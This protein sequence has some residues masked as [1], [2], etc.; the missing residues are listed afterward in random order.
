VRRHLNKAIGVGL[1][2]IVSL[3]PLSCSRAQPN[4]SEECCAD[5]SVDR[6]LEMPPIPDEL[7]AGRI[8]VEV[9]F[10]AKGVVATL[11]DRNHKIVYFYS[12]D[13]GTSWRR[14]EFYQD[15]RAWQSHI[16]RDGEI[17]PWNPNPADASVRYR[18][19]HFPERK[20]YDERST[21][22]GKSWTR[23]KGIILGC[24]AKMGKGGT[25]F[26]HPRDPLT[27]Y[28]NSFLPGWDGEVMFVSVD[29]G[30]TFRSM[31]ES[32]GA[33]LLAISHSNPKVMYGAGPSGSLLKSTDGGKLWDLVGQ[34]DP[35]RRTRVRMSDVGTGSSGKAFDEWPTDIDD[36][37]IDPVDANRVYVAT[38]KG[39]LRTE[40]GG[41]TWCILDAGMTKARAIHSIAIVPTQPDV[42]FV[43]TY[44]GLARS[45][46]KGCHW[47]WID[48]LSRVQK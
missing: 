12:E 38:S 34:N 21:D 46:G 4:G 28:L 39:I 13:G 26:Y 9:R 47:E 17:L 40:N 16:L 14:D 22:G 45:V 6:I 20:S 11:A 30:D 33:P 48:V 35:I 2:L 41:E 37:A 36:I 32:A 44:K 24:N 5:L 1:S 29:G 42:L 3:L 8:N 19:I 23:M 15:L 25:Y 18:T 7:E 10:D 43:G 27:L 31:Y